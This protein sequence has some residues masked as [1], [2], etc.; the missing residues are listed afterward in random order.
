MKIFVHCT[1]HGR[2]HYR[3]Q[4]HIK[5]KL[6]YSRTISLN[7]SII[8]HFSTHHANIWKRQSMTVSGNYPY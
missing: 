7:D 6:Y 3:K 4:V 2:G 5:K 1:V 8:L